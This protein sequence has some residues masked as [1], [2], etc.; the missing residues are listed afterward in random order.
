MRVAAVCI[1]KD[2][3]NYLEEWVEYHSLLGIDGMFVYQNDWRFRPKRKWDAL[4]L[5]EFDGECRQLAAYSDFLLNRSEPYDYAAFIDADEFICLNFGCESVKDY[6]GEF[7]G[8]FGNCCG[9]ALNWRLFGDNGLRKVKN[10]DYSLLN[11]FTRCESGLNRHVKM[12]LN[13]N[14][15]RRLRK[16]RND[17]FE[18]VNPHSIREA[19][20]YPCVLNSSFTRR[21]FGHFNDGED[22]SSAKVWINHYF[23]KT[24]EE[25][26]TN[27]FNKGKADFVRSSPKQS[28]DV[29][30]FDLHN[31]NDVE[32][33]VA[34][35]FYNARRGKD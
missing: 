23:C 31:R 25:F 26:M 35:D 9:I 10:G 30:L 18:F 14:E 19:Y 16:T 29:T 20:L 28:L 1:A 8:R 17:V 7:G 4:E 5:V 21:V 22:M 27:K 32:C 12:V 2:E 11:R 6:L 15:Y 13:L 24:R 33:T 3:D 34:R